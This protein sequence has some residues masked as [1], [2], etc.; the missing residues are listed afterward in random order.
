MPDESHKDVAN[1]EEGDAELKN[2][3]KV[4]LESRKVASPTSL[5]PRRKYVRRKIGDLKSPMIDGTR[6]GTIR[7]WIKRTEKSN[8][9]FGND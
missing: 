6:N 8:F 7:E 3:F 9:K 2:A 5:T 4:L 1:K